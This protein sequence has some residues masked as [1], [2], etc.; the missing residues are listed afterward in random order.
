MDSALLPLELYMHMYV[1]TY[2]HTYIH[3][4]I[5]DP[6]G[7]QCTTS[8][9]NEAVSIDVHRPHVFTILYTAWMMN[10]PSK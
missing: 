6:S 9:I 1:H 3:S 5:R 10:E 4:Y 8:F 7:A 2:T